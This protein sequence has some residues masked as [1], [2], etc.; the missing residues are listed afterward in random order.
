MLNRIPGGEE[1]LFPI[2]RVV[3]QV[4]GMIFLSLLVSP[5]IQIMEDYH[6]YKTC[7]EACLNCAA[8]CNH[9]ASSCTQEEDVKM[10]ATCIQLDME[11]SALCY[12]AAQL[13]SL[14]PKQAKAICSICADLCEACGNECGQHHTR[15]C[16]ECAAAC[17]ACAAECRK[18]AA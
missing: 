3:N 2:I 17:K 1:Q 12:A 15:H 18:M 11:C 4:V 8:I 5:K 10:M 14:G 13:M 16:Q 9:C 6:T 7:I